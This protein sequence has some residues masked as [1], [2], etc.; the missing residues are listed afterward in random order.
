MGAAGKREGLSRDER[1]RT[2]RDLDRVFR[3]GDHIYAPNFVIIS[4]RNELGFSRVGAI[5]G[6]KSGTAVERNRVKR[7]IREFFRRNKGVI[8]VPADYVI[9][10]RKGARD[11]RYADVV[12]ELQGVMNPKGPRHE[13]TER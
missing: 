2:R 9:I 3:D 11:L 4:R 10:G 13:S 6:K 12:R 8:R 7:L 1:L 5:S